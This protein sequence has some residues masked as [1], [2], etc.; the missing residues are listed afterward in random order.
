MSATKAITNLTPDSVDD[1][2][3]LQL[4][5]AA[6]TGISFS[7]FENFI[8]TTP[9]TL[10]D[11]AAC[12]PVSY[13]TLQ[14]YRESKG[15]VLL[16]KS[17]SEKILEISFLFT[18]GAVVFGN[19]DTFFSWLTTRNMALGGV[20]PKELLDTT[21]GINMLKDELTRIEHGVLA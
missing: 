8:K 14:R 18:R 15:P 3:A 21:F 17:I 5:K 6:R 1:R 10:A 2:D 9:L 12:L 20:A 13:R 11:W 4:I 16:D 7:A 19:P